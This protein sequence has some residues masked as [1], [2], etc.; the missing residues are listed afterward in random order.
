MVTLPDLYCLPTT[1]SAPIPIVT[2]YVCIFS[3]YLMVN[4]QGL[5]IIRKM[6]DVICDNLIENYVNLSCGNILATF[7]TD[8]LI[9]KTW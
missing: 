9:L 3:G 7:T 6:S 4:S 5:V 2:I 1:L 8:T